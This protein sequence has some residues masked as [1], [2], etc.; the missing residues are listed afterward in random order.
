M[1]RV[2]LPSIVKVQKL[3]LTCN[4]CGASLEESSA[5]WLE[6]PTCDWQ[7]AYCAGC[8]EEMADGFQCNDCSERNDREM[9]PVTDAS[10]LAD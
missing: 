10:A 5:E 4:G 1:P 8:A 2:E 3:E 6:C 7:Y 9:L